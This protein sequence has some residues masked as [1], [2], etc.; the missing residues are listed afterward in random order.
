MTSTATPPPLGAV[1][2]SYLAM[3]ARQPG[4]AALQA[5]QEAAQRL[6]RAHRLLPAEPY[7]ATTE[8]ATSLY[9]PPEIVAEMAEGAE[10]TGAFRVATAWREVAAEMRLGALTV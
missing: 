5:A 4:Q 10:R 2:S 8:T 6:D 7:R 9:V 3:R 1:T